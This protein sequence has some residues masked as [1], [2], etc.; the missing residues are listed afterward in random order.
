[1]KREKFILGYLIKTKKKILTTEILKEAYVD[2]FHVGD[3]FMLI[4]EKSVIL[5]FDKFG[6]W[7]VKESV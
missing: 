5:G 7:L 1:M 4:E 3:S 2:M 6:A